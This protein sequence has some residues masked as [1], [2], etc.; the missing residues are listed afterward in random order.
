MTNVYSARYKGF[1]TS[2]FY[3]I[4]FTINIV[5][6]THIY[7]VLFL[8]IITYFMIGN[9]NTETVIL[10]V[11]RPILYYIKIVN[12]SE[13][14]NSHCCMDFYFLTNCTYINIFVQVTY[15]VIPCMSDQKKY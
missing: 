14:I 10:Y 15:T 5:K 2:S 9:E 4:L 7:N 8:E 11:L 1:M 12:H 13:I 6:H 3:L